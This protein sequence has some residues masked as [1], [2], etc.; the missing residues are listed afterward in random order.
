MSFKANILQKLTKKCDSQYFDFQ[1]HFGG[2]NDRDRKMVSLE[3]MLIVARSILYFCCNI[4]FHR[5]GAR[6]PNFE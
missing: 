6:C 4:E 3:K 5:S 2:L 1:T